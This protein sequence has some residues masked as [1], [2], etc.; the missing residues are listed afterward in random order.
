MRDRVYRDLLQELEQIPTV[1]THEHLPLE[2]LRIEEQLDFFSLF[3]HYCI[4]DLHSAGATEEDFEFWRNR[5]IE[6][7][8]RWKR[9]S[10]FLDCIRT[11]GYCQSVMFVVRDILGFE[12][13]N[14]NTYE[15]VSCALQ[16]ANRRGIYDEILHN[17]C[18]IIATIQCVMPEQRK[19]DP[20][21][22]YQLALSHELVDINSLEAV[23]N[24]SHRCRK[25]IHS[26][27][28]ILDCMTC[29][30]EDWSV[31]PRI[32]GV[33]SIHA[34][35]R[36]LGFTEVSKAEAAKVTTNI[37][38]GQSQSLSFGETILL[39]DYLMFELAKRLQAVDLPMVFHTG[40]QAGNFN[41]ITNANPLLLE[42]LLLEFPRL[43]VDLYHGG[44]PWVREIGVLEKYFPGVHLNMAWL[45]IIN[46]AQARSALS[47][48]LDSVPNSKIFGFG[49]D[50]RIVEKV[51]GHLVLAK[52]NIARVLASKVAEKTYTFEHACAIAKRLMLDNPARFYRLNV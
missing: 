13:L 44:P 24:L 11:T 19:E 42:N 2:S 45:H 33:K 5:Q 50:Y 16:E 8:R 38:R 1:D 18:N 30:V 51:Y 26:L 10:P 23:K 43:R 35:S 3:E 37:L 34:Y 25:S 20:E 36:S 17:R 28:D 31:E 29:V 40:L 7:K 46:P 12:D 14:E 41:R 52:Q 15:G 32:V 49:G 47:E 4:G 9:F 27:D 22:F 39:Q 21:D 6:L 48:W